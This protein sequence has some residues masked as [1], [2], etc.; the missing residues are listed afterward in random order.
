MRNIIF[1][2]FLSLSIVVR[3][4]DI[5]VTI[6]DGVESDA[7][8]QKMERNIMQIL[9]EI[10]AAQAADRNLDF[11]AMGVGIDVQRSMAMLWENTPFLC[12]DEEIVEHCITTNS[13]YQVRNIPLMMKPTAERA[14]N[15]EEYQEAVISF[16][17]QGNVVSFYLSVSMNLYMNVIKSNLELTDLRR[18]Q[19]ILDYVEQFRTAYNQKD[20]KFLNQVFSDDALIITGKVIMQKHAEGFSSQ[21]IEYNKQS[22]K[23][24]IDKL[25]RIF[26]NARYFK[27][28]FDEIEVMRHPTNPNFYGVTLLQ[29]YTNNSYHDDGYLFLLWDFTNEN[30]P[31]IHVR[32]WQPDKVGGKPLPKDE[33]FTLG[34]FDI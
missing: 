33:V 27:I 24:Y 17:K 13:G 20:I 22:K 10:N 31:Q 7:L 19:M 6:T 15:E 18:R 2:L 21:K 16:D 14:F 34:D 5:S 23:E 29:G 32:T 26:Q 30:Q 1:C 12:T 3:A 11:S 25:R 9:N 4:F 8:R 28:T